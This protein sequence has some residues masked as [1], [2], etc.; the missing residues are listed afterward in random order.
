MPFDPDIASATETGAVAT[1]YAVLMGFL[2]ILIVGG[3]TAFGLGLS[4]YYENVVAAIRALL[5]V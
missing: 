3:I 5:G 4:N 2:V 1:E